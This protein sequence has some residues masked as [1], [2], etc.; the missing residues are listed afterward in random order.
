MA[1]KVRSM[2]RRLEEELSEWLG[3]DIPRKGTEDYETWKNREAEIRTIETYDDV[4]NYLGGND[5]LAREFF[6]DFGIK[7][8]EAVL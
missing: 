5:E 1:D 8:F 3:S 7:D 6:C 2:K 4:Y